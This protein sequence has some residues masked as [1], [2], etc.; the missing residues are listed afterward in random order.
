MNT[1]TQTTPLVYT[2]ESTD[3]LLLALEFSKREYVRAC[4]RQAEAW[5]LYE[6]AIDDSDWEA[7]AALLS[8]AQ[9]A[10]M[11]QADAYQDREAAYAAYWG[12]VN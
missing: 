12:K 11:Q 8:I 1:A 9:L 3:H 4:D 5:H 6:E 7:I 10:D 2:T